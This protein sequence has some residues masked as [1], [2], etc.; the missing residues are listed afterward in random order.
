VTRAQR[1]LGYSPRVGIE[2]GIARFCAW[3]KEQV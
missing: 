1:E 2:D 3:V